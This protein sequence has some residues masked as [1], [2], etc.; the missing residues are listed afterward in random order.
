MAAAL[1]FFAADHKHLLPIDTLFPPARRLGDP[2][3]TSVDRFCW[4]WWH[5]PGQYTLLRT[6]AEAF[7]PADLYD[8]LE[9][10]LIAYGERELGCRGIS[11]IW[12]RWAW[13]AVRAQQRA[14][15]AG[16]C[17]SHRLVQAGFRW[18][19]PE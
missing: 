16:V 1:W 12:L 6:P 18:V 10:A 11:P 15:M 5:V 4:D 9:D 7:F 19:L 17:G 8:Q 3:S 2:L 13:A 14:C